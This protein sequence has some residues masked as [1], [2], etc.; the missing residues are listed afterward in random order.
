VDE[1]RIRFAR[2]A[3]AQVAENVWIV[4]HEPINTAGLRLPIRM[5]IIRLSSGDLLVHSPTRY[6]SALREELE[7]LGTIRY[8][9][10]P[11]IAH[12]MFI[13]GW[14]QALPDTITLAVPG[15]AARRQVRDA[16]L[17]V[18]REVLD[19]TPEEWGDEI[20]TVLISAPLFAEIALFHMKIQA[21]LNFTTRIM[22][23][24]NRL[25]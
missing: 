1:A 5:T 23:P 6:S 3:V 12:W 25:S 8:L 7:R 16:G 18:D 13:P 4:D 9:L 11:S 20:E 14:Q 17:R 19:G 15:L 10:A 21:M 22:A 2:G 24:A